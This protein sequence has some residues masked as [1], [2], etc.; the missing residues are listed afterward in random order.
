MTLKALLIPT[1]VLFIGSADAL[2]MTPA[3]HA[4][5]TRPARVSTKRS[6]EPVGIRVAKVDSASPAIPVRPYSSRG[7]TMTKYRQSKTK[8]GGGRGSIRILR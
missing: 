2:A 4:H 6:L 5:R 7:H 1:L 8:R 3:G